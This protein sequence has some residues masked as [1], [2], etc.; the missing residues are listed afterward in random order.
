MEGKKEK[1]S[2][3]EK[4]VGEIEKRKESEKPDGRG[5]LAEEGSSRA[6]VVDLSAIERAVRGGAKKEVKVS[7]ASRITSIFSDEIALSEA[8]VAPLFDSLELSLLEADVA[9]DVCVEM[10]SELKKSLIGRRVSKKRIG[11]EVKKAVGEVLAK[12]M[13][14]G[15]E[16]DLVQRIKGTQKPAKILFVGPNGAG[17]TTT[18]AKMADL[19]KRNSL[20]VLFSASDT[21]RAAAIEQMQ[22]HADKLDVKMVKSDYGSDPAAVAFDAVN[23]ARAHNFDVVLIDSAGRQETNKNLIDELK[24]IVRVV[25]PDLKI[26]VGESFG[27]NPIIGQIG[28]FDKAV[29][30]DGVILTKLDCDAKGGSAIS[31]ARATH[32]PVLYVG[33]GQEYADLKRFEPLEVARGILE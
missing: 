10:V 23:Y 18:I 31:V 12:T 32:V 25:K 7:I 20:S 3:K 13:T 16:F 19:L 30:L 24:K 4:K 22:V 9:Y 6:P 11:E 33:V 1:Y 27:G 14:T 28:E 21:F 5:M 8:D 15:K 26:Y 2:E 17:K 29:G